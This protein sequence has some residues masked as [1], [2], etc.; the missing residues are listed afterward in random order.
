VNPDEPL[1]IARKD[2]L[3]LHFLSA[4]T[5]DILGRG[6]SVQG[7]HACFGLTAYTPGEC[8]AAIEAADTALGLGAPTP[9]QQAMGD[10]ILNVT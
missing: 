4:L 6:L 5:L 1:T 10:L 8:I 7:A 3:R 2:L 9:E